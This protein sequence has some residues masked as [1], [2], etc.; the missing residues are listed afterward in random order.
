MKAIPQTDKGI[1]LLKIRE[2]ERIELL[3][4]EN[5]NFVNGFLFSE[6]QLLPLPIGST[7]RN[8]SFCW[9]PGPGFLGDYRFQFIV[10]DKDGAFRKREVV[11][12]IEPRFGVKK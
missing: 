12:R 4:A 1:S 10:K 6:N 8:A 9:M 3:L 2:L 11:I 5:E 7:L